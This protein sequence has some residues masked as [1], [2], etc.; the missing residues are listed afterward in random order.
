V[1]SFNDRENLFKQPLSDYD[2]LA[3]VLTTFE[4][5]HKLWDLAMEFDLD[6]Q[7]WYNGPF[8]RL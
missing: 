7:D 1:K 3:K 5:Y 8:L 4:P 6:K 2:D